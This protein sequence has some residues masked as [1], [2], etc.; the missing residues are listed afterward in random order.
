MLQ[1]YLKRLKLLIKTL[2]EKYD[3]FYGNHV[4]D[5][6]IILPAK[7]KYISQ[8]IELVEN[9]LNNI[10][11]DNNLKCQI[12]P[13]SPQIKNVMVQNFIESPI[14]NKQSINPINKNILPYNIPVIK[15]VNKKEESVLDKIGKSNT[16]HYTIQE[17][18]KK[19][20]FDLPKF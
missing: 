18:R 1:S 7:I 19:A 8:Q 15:V 12:N 10:E 16:K 6:N 14:H 2:K 13:P 3:I 11:I 20:L 5:D 9:Y 4:D 17:K